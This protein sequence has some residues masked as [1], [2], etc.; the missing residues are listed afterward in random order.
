MNSYFV[1]RFSSSIEDCVCVCKTEQISFFHFH[2]LDVYSSPFTLDSLLIVFILCITHKMPAMNTNVQSERS[3]SA[4]KSNGKYYFYS[5]IPF[6]CS[7][8][9]EMFAERA[10]GKDSSN[11]KWN[12][13]LNSCFGLRFIVLVPGM[14]KGHSCQCVP[15]FLGKKSHYLP[16]IWNWWWRKK[17]EKKIKLITLKI[18]KEKHQFV[19]INSNHT[20][21]KNFNK[22]ETN[23]S[24]ASVAVHK[25]THKCKMAHSECERQRVSVFGQEFSRFNSI[26]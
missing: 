26:T 14:W 18:V 15:I 5:E 16:S 8:S 21:K 22:I 12:H 3:N 10:T 19:F 24:E 13:L 9:L 1:F 2:S 23:C 25:C 6:V 4:K 20:H 17:R 7:S 11:A